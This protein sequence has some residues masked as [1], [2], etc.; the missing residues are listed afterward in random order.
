MDTI[1][2][3]VAGLDVHLKGEGDGSLFRNC[4]RPLPSITSRFPAY[5]EPS[6]PPLPREVDSR[7]WIP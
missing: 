1:Y 3:N 7:A 4:S 6:H 5:S 2:S